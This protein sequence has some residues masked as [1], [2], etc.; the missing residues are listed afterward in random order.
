[1]ALQIDVISDV[2]CPWCYIGKRK[3]A[4]ALDLYRKR[5][6]GAEQPRV[7][8]H[9]FQ[10]NPEMPAAGVDRAEYLERKFGGRS[11]DI[12]ARVTAVGAELGIPF[13]FDKVPRQPNTLAAHSLIA[14]AADEGVQDDVVEALFRAYFIDGR[15]LTSN[16]TLSAIA[17]EA[18]L[19][20]KDVD[21]CLAGPQAREQVQAE[22]GQARRLGVEG[23]PFFIFNRRYAVSGAQDPE[24][25]FDAMLK[26]ASEATADE[27]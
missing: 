1:M 12:Y 9:P 16:E 7:T 25:L 26:S 14:L 17:C 5:N 6:P 4:L 27:A 10:L 22:D 18:G 15:D 24:A 11:T 3:L 19:A 20:R 23:V 21:T 13:A 8:W 2:V